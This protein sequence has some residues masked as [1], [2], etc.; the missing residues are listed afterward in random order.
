MAALQGRTRG[1]SHRSRVRERLFRRPEE[2]KTGQLSGIAAEWSR[3]GFK[4]VLVEEIRHELHVAP[5]VEGARI[6]HWLPRGDDFV[7]RKYRAAE[8][9]LDK[10]RPGKRR[11]R[12]C[13]GERRAM[14]GRAT[15]RHIG[16]LS[17]LDLTASEFDRS[18]PGG[19]GWA[20]VRCGQRRHQILGRTCARQG[21]RLIR[22]EADIGDQ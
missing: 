7:E 18:K 22:E 9:A 19:R 17:D 5:W 21:G 2:P 8:P 1:L 15:E 11:G 12:G 14:A 6:V 16:L 20:G 13:S 4:T 3:P 10:H